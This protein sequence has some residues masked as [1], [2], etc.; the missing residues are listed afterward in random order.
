[1]MEIGMARLELWQD[2]G[3]SNMEM[4]GE[5]NT[6]EEAVK[7]ARAL[8]SEDLDGNYWAEMYGEVIRFYIFDRLKSKGRRKHKLKRIRM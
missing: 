3:L 2:R 1:M 6:E 4:V 5:F 7:R 8:Y